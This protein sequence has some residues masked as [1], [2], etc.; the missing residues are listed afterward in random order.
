MTA[1]RFGDSTRNAHIGTLKTKPACLAIMHLKLGMLWL[2]RQATYSVWKQYS[3]RIQRDCVVRG[4]QEQLPLRIGRNTTLRRL[5]FGWL[6]DHFRAMSRGRRMLS[7]R[8]SSV[9]KRNAPAA[10]TRALQDQQQRTRR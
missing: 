10:Q 9:P 2:L 7:M 3:L 6:D 5:V 8:A 1:S 4:K